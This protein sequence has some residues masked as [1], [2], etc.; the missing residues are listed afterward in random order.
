MYIASKQMVFGESRKLIPSQGGPTTLYNQGGNANHYQGQLQKYQGLSASQ[1]GG[2]GSGGK[3]QP[4]QNNESSG[5]EKSQTLEQWN[6]M[7]SNNGSRT[8]SLARASAVGAS[9][10]AVV[11]DNEEEILRFLDN[12]VLED[13]PTEVLVQLAQKLK[14]RR[15]KLYTENNSGG[16]LNH[17]IQQQGVK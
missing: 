11:P 1:K 4:Q 13:Q 2:I 8:G 12:A 17:A 16:L 7:N 6:V 9:A 14:D 3:Q 15:S 10:S 5:Q